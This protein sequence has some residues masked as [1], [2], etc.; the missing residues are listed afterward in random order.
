MNCN[1]KPDP[2]IKSFFMRKDRCAD[3]INAFLFHGEEV[4]HEDNLQFYDCESSVVIDSDTYPVS[5]NRTRDILFKVTLDDFEFLLGF[6]IQN[7][8]DST[9][10]YRVY[11][12][13]YT[14]INRQKTS[15]D[16]LIP[17]VTLVLYFG[18]FSWTGGYSLFD[19]IPEYLQPFIE[20]HKMFLYEM[21]DVD[22]HLFGYKDTRDLV[23]GLQRIYALGDIQSL[24]HM[25]MDKDVGLVLMSIVHNEE[26][27][28]IVKQQKGDVINM[29]TSLDRLV[30][31]SKSIGREEG[32][33]EGMKVGITI[34]EEHGITIG[35]EQGKHL[36]RMKI[37][38]KLI[39]DC[40]MSSEQ[41]FQILEIPEQDKALFIVS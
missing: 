4:V 40:Q 19:D 6:E 7:S 9:M 17:V 1:L 10:P 26:L 32:R 5:M 37:F 38:K 30:E 16:S 11:E 14:A 28:E 33:S 29:C 36:E 12:Y 31:E 22:Y 13:D 20:E 3:I 35:Q 41:A 24:R 2:T 18:E 39:K 27:L 34:G 21:K 23:E 8:V 15:G 25:D